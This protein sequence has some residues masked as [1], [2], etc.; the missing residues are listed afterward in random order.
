MRII[1][2]KNT[3]L[4]AATQNT[5]VPKLGIKFEPWPDLEKIMTNLEL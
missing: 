1:V 3:N 4:L 5:Y 2:E